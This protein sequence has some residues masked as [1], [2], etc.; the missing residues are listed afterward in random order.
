[1]MRSSVFLRALFATLVFAARLDAQEPPPRLPIIVVDVH[2]NLPNFPDTQ[3]LADSRLLNLAELPGLGFGGDLGL[4]LYP[5]TWRQVT[6][7]VGAQLT[8]AQAHRT[9][10]PGNI[11]LRPVTERFASLSPQLSF[12]FGSGDGWSYL[13]GGISTS[14]WSV[15]PDGLDQLPPDLERLKTLNYGGGARWFAKPHLAFS[16]DVRFYAINPSTPVGGLPKGPRTTLLIVGAGI[17]LK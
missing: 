6:F 3:G 5:F 1:M 11:T 8:L 15:V 4:H 7:G 10:D 14:Q 13:S 12:N 2:G 9:P 16:F 17:S